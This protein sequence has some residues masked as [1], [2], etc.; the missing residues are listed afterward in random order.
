MTKS[1]GFTLLE[2]LIALAILGVIAYVTFASIKQISIQGSVLI[3]KQQVVAKLQTAIAI[4]E[5]DFLQIAPRDIRNED[6]IFIP[7]MYL[8]INGEIEFSRAGSAPLDQINLQRVSYKLDGDKLYRKTWNNLDR[9][10]G[11]VGAS[12]IILE[13]VNDF[14]IELLGEEGWVSEWP[15]SND[16]SYLPRMIKITLDIENQKHVTRI[17]AGV[18]N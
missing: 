10:I 17:L 12:A 9:A 4:M 14:N 7:A 13:Q 2:L 3:E 15:E 1:R 11:D 16:G 5:N 6:G 8:D 18:S